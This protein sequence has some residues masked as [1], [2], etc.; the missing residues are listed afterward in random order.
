MS[1]ERIQEDRIGLIE[2]YRNA[3][4]DEQKAEI[5]DR[6]MATLNDREK[7]FFMDAQAMA[8]RIAHIDRTQKALE[9]KRNETVGIA[10]VL[11]FPI[12]ENVKA[13]NYNVLLTDTVNKLDSDELT[14]QYESN[15]NIKIVVDAVI[16]AKRNAIQIDT[17]T[18]TD[19]KAEFKKNNLTVPVKAVKEVRCKASP[20]KKN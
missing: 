8:G 10:Q 4:T 12:G 16:I 5:R 14:A 18:A 7:A 13:G 17:L 11:G 15:D 20:I 6:L 1:T 2:S 9:K 19:L 3:Q